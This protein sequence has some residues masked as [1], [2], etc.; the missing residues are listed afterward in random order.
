M[1]NDT[2]DNYHRG[3]FFVVMEKQRAK[4]NN[5]KTNDEVKF[6]RHK[7]HADKA[8]CNPRK[9]SLKGEKVVNCLKFREARRPHV[10]TL[11]KADPP[12]KRHKSDPGVIAE[13]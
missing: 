1:K 7:A 13:A 11:V 6:N 8:I 9:S 2:L 10:R 3:R 4:Y 12:K 5:H